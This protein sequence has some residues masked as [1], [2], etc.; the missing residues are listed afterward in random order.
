MSPPLTPGADEAR[1]LLEQELSKPEYLNPQ[2]WLS[3]LLDRLLNWLVGDRRVPTMDDGQ[4]TALIVGVVLLV[5][6]VGVALWVFLGPLGSGRLRSGEV[7]G[8]DETRT[9]AEMRA[10]A[11]RLAEAEEWGPATQQCFRAMVRSLDERAIIEPNPGLTALEAARRAAERLPSVA[12]RLTDAAAVFDGLAYGGRPGSA[13]HYRTMQALDADVAGLR[14]TL[15]G[16]PAGT[17]AA[18]DVEVVE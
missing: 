4:A 3:D 10:D 16:P 2:G 1:L 18:V 12:G 7:F 8:D 17:P 5:V 15:P 11:V 13:E 14:P 9:A 6:A